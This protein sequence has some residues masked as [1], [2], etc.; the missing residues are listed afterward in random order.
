LTFCVVE[1]IPLKTLAACETFKMMRGCSKPQRFLV[2]LGSVRTK[3]APQP[4]RVG[5]RVAKFCVR[6]LESRG[7]SVDLVDP[8]EWPLDE[9]PSSFRPHFS[10]A[11]G[12]APGRADELAQLIA[13]ADGFVTV[14]PEY[15]HSMSP[16]LANMLNHFGSSLFSYKPSLIVAYS[17]GQWGGARAAVNMRTY[18][19]ELG[20]LSV[21]AQ[22]LVPQAHKVLD[23]DGTLLPEVDENQWAGY[24]GRGFDQLE[25]WSEATKSQREKV[26]LS[27]AAFKS[28]PA[29]RNA[30]GKK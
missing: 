2:F 12:R 6:G 18:L 4:T 15:N 3:G 19:G 23:T 14:S 1:T 26:D 8:L 11:K 22:I 16:A 28:N 9:D 5:E 29:Q 24:S 17:M 21:S 7:H 30:P 27:S 13:D 20:C 10:Y 25:W